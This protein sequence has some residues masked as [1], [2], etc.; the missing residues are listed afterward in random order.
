MPEFHRDLV[1]VCFAEAY[2]GERV[3]GELSDVELGAL[4]RLQLKM[5]ENMGLFLLAN[6][7][8]DVSEDAL[9]EDAG[10]TVAEA[11]A[12]MRCSGDIRQRALFAEALSETRAVDDEIAYELLRFL[13]AAIK[14]VCE[15]EM[16]EL[17]VVRAFD[18]LVPWLSRST[19]EPE[20]VSAIGEYVKSIV[21]GWISSVNPDG[22]WTGVSHK[23][24]ISRA[25]LTSAAYIPGIRVSAEQIDSCYLRY[26]MRERSADVR[27]ELLRIEA[28]CAH[29]TDI[30]VDYAA[31]DIAFLVDVLN[32]D[33]SPEKRID[34]CTA[35]FDVL[36]QLYALDLMEIIDFDSGPEPDAPGTEYPRA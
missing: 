25:A 24:G 12:R 21:E 18:A 26:V 36:L 4:L 7:V 14:N 35:L 34:A 8:S 5:A 9:H 11:L 10:I 1:S 15:D 13:E 30:E 17:S 32:G 31:G 19:I 6:P 16:V 23:V 3:P 28:R 29:Y 27:T 2:G 33:I 22:S 20:R